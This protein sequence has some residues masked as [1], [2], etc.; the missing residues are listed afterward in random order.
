MIGPYRRPAGPLFPALRRCLV[1]VTDLSPVEAEAKLW[2]DRY[3]ATFVGL[4]LSAEADPAPLL[5]YF[6]VPLTLTTAAAHTVI[7][8][9][10]ALLAGLG[11]ELRA[12]RE[13]DYGGST[14]HDPVVRALNERSVLIEVVWSRHDRAG[15][16][17][18]RSRMLYLVARTPAG[19]RGTAVVVLSD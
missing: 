1:S 19:W 18:Q 12:F 6:A 5:D 7:G 14:A 13:A 9:T 3:T 8:T 11:Q 4:A 10:E 16:E 15:A 2:F 17:F